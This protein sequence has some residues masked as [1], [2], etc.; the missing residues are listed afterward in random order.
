MRSRK[1]LRDKKIIRNEILIKRDSI[2]P[3]KKKEK[4][5]LIMDKVFSLPYF[6]KAKTAFYF[7]S[8][9]SE[10]STLPQIEE[11]LRRGKRIILPK[12]DNINKRLRL[13]EIHNTGEIKPGFMG[14]PEPD[15]PPER[16]RDINDVDLVIM[17]GVAFDTNGNRL[18]YG[19]GYYDKLLS[20]LKKKIPLI[21]IAYEE[22]IVD[23]LPAESHDVRVNMIVTDERI[24]EIKNVP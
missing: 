12:V 18:G 2:D 19:A 14:I 3:E 20:G 10:V 13:F 15:V 24:I 7:V 21:A 8:F 16:E 11:A 17:P 5:R 22:Q 6:E 9:R 1:G 23:S 4:D